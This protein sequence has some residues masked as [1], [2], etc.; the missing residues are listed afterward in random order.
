MDRSDQLISFSI[1]Q[2]RHNQPEVMKSG[3]LQPSVLATLLA[4]VIWRSDP[5]CVIGG[6]VLPDHTALAANVTESTGASQYCQSTDICAPKEYIVL[7]KKLTV[8]G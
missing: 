3:R 2:V 4:L 6:I 8:Q 5:L 1:P 7:L